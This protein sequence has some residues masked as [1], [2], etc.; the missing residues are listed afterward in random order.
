LTEHAQ[1]VTDT[2]SRLRPLNAAG[3]NQAIGDVKEWCVFTCG[4]ETAFLQQVA[5]VTEEYRDGL[6]LTPA[7]LEEIKK[8]HGDDLSDAEYQVIK[9]R[10]EP[11]LKLNQQHEELFLS[12]SGQSAVRQKNSTVNASQSPLAFLEGAKMRVSEKVK[13]RA[14]GEVT[15]TGVL[16]ADFSPD[17]KWELKSLEKRVV[18]QPLFKYAQAIDQLDKAATEFFSGKNSMALTEARLNAGARHQLMTNTTEVDIFTAKQNYDSGQATTDNANMTWKEW[19]GRLRRGM[20]TTEFFADAALSALSAKQFAAAEVLVTTAA[21]INQSTRESTQALQGFGTQAQNIEQHGTFVKNILRRP[22]SWVDWDDWSGYTHLKGAKEDMKQYAEGL[23]QLLKATD[24]Q[25]EKAAWSKIRSE[26]GK[27]EDKMRFIQIKAPIFE[28]ASFILVTAVT[29]GAGTLLTQG[30]LR[31]GAWAGARGLSMT[32]NPV[33]ITGSALSNSLAGYTATGIVLNAAEAGWITRSLYSVARLGNLRVMT[34]GGEMLVTGGLGFARTVALSV[35]QSTAG[36]A[37]TTFQMGAGAVAFENAASMLRSGKFLSTAENL[38]TFREG[39][40][41]GAMGPLFAAG[42]FLRGLNR[43][44]RFI[45]ATHSP[46]SSLIGRFAPKSFAASSKAAA[47]FAWFPKFTLTSIEGAFMFHTRMA[48]FTKVAQGIGHRVWGGEGKSESQL[49]GI[50]RQAHIIGEALAIGTPGRMH[51]PRAYISRESLKGLRETL[52]D[53]AENTP[54]KEARKEAIK[55]ARAEYLEIAIG[56]RDLIGALGG[57]VRTGPLL[58]AL[59]AVKLKPNGNNLVAFQKIQGILKA[60]IPQ[61]TR[62]ERSTMAQEILSAKGAVKGGKF[63]SWSNFEQNAARSAARLAGSAPEGSAARFNH[64]RL[65]L[66]KEVFRQ[67]QSGLKDGSLHWSGASAPAPKSP[68]LAPALS[69]IARIRLALSAVAQLW[70][71]PAPAIKFTAVKAAIEKIWAEP[72]PA[73]GA[74]NSP[75]AKTAPSGTTAAPDASKSSVPAEVQQLIGNMTNGAS[76]PAKLKI[77]NLLMQR[78]VSELAGITPA[79]RGKPDLKRQTIA[80]AI[81]RTAELFNKTLVDASQTKGSNSKT[82]LELIDTA[83]TAARALETTFGPKNKELRGIAKSVSKL[84]QS[85]LSPVPPAKSGSGSRPDLALVGRALALTGR[86]LGRFAEATR[87]LSKQLVQTLNPKSPSVARPSVSEVIKL[88]T[89]LGSESRQAAKAALQVLKTTAKELLADKTGLKNKIESANTAEALTNQIKDL[90]RGLLEAFRI[91][92]PSRQVRQTAGLV[93][94]LIKL[95]ANAFDASKITNAAEAKGFG[96]ALQNLSEA[97]L[98]VARVLGPMSQKVRAAARAILGASKAYAAKVNSMLVEARS[99]SQAD[100]A[101]MAEGLYAATE[102]FYAASV[103]AGIKSSERKE[104][105]DNVAKDFIEAANKLAKKLDETSINNSDSVSAA[106]MLL[107]M[108]DVLLEA[109]LVDADAVRNYADLIAGKLFG[110]GATAEILNTKLTNSTLNDIN[111]INLAVVARQVLAARGL[112][113]ADIDKALGGAQA[114]ALIAAEVAL[115]AMKTNPPATAD[116]YADQAE[117]IYRAQMTDAAR[118]KVLGALITQMLQSGNA[119]ALQRFSERAAKNEELAADLESALILFTV[120]GLEKKIRDANLELE[121]AVAERMAQELKSIMGDKNGVIGSRGVDMNRHVFVRGE[122]SRQAD[123]AL[124]TL[125]T[126]GRFVSELRARAIRMS[127][128][129][130]LE[131][132]KR[133]K[134]LGL[135]PEVLRNG[136][137]LAELGANPWIKIEAESFTREAVRAALSDI[138]GSTRASERLATNFIRRMIK[139]A[140]SEGQN[141]TVVERALLRLWEVLNHQANPLDPNSIFIQGFRRTDFTSEVLAEAGKAFAEGLGRLSAAPEP[142]SESGVV[143]KA[144]LPAEADAASVLARYLSGGAKEAWTLLKRGKYTT[145]T[146][147]KLLEALSEDQPTQSD[148]S[149]SAS[150]ETP[151]TLEQQAD[152]DAI[153]YVLARRLSEQTIND[154]LKVAKNTEVDFVSKNA[155]KPETT[156][157]SVPVEGKMDSASVNEPKIKADGP[158]IEA[159]NAFLSSAALTADTARLAKRG[160]ALELRGKMSLLGNWLTRLSRLKPFR[161]LTADGRKLS[162]LEREARAEDQKLQ[163]EK[164]R[165]E[166]LLEALSKSSSEEADTSIEPESEGIKG[167]REYV[168]DFN[169]SLNRERPGR[170]QYSTAQ[171][172]YHRVLRTVSNL[173]HQLGK[174]LNPDKGDPRSAVDTANELLR[175]RE[176]IDNNKLLSPF[177]RNLLTN[178]ITEILKIKNDATSEVSAL[179]KQTDTASQNAKTAQQTAGKRIIAFAESFDTASSKIKVLKAA[180]AKAESDL[181]QLE[182]ELQKLKMNQSDNST[183]VEAKISDAKTVLNEARKAET[184]A[185]KDAID[186]FNSSPSGSEIPNK[187][188]PEEL[189]K[190]DLSPEQILK[191]SEWVREHIRVLIEARHTTPAQKMQEVLSAWDALI[192]SADTAKKARAD[193][194]KNKTQKITLKNVKKLESQSRKLEKKSFKET[195]RNKR[196]KMRKEAA[197]ALC[198]AQFPRANRAYPIP[199]AHSP[200]REVPPRARQSNRAA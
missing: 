46:I 70:R 194:A 150:A 9:D 153:R 187:I 62:G 157:E 2:I 6:F 104:K 120:E 33:L 196:D 182:L 112:S 141:P 10:L 129:R 195:D 61:L 99:G 199:P 67:I 174:E 144:T 27:F 127:E 134:Q 65:A 31:F 154:I 98:S 101:Q 85:E 12:D 166:K 146:D 30:A 114:R 17:D 58:D 161:W 137:D 117:L 191:G 24:A 111:F 69:Y 177:N 51:T 164:S 23:A 72:V 139:V 124:D 77:L 186:T 49:R 96:K 21:S 53:V 25:S 47:F 71:G 38:N 32:A 29:W 52:K 22:L 158:L 57:S 151:K 105:V 108:Y 180:T 155:P 102:A 94:N 121:S 184:K 131:Q 142:T 20:E 136:L 87:S 89:N 200:W 169:D 189:A 170:I 50:D 3:V 149:A 122:A 13:V 143:K 183:G 107:S 18:D 60:A 56:P 39:L 76:R 113:E 160:Q 132:V 26:S 95:A 192:A 171:R 35:I 63:I 147:Q 78:L 14:A 15:L 165:L 125:R 138:E 19:E 55:K 135:S 84:A 88:L 91:L 5:T 103:L 79:E 118:G 90:S 44:S 152:S 172:A 48:F 82:R 92:G 167:L 123:R 162:S 163:N 109:R 106:R 36:V 159:I 188:T 97:L 176:N 40:W 81:K 80:D 59:N 115:T 128:Q 110:E 83:L 41:M 11:L 197:H 198:G 193:F 133:I 100:I 178:L 37:W 8:T 185:M 86:I 93:A 148:L 119:D 168:R 4:D 156:T 74:K 68:P 54:N 43:T 34:A 28:I 66:T 130:V 181:N 42:Q 1:T 7:R 64:Q 116:A 140:K 173:A 145:F 190:F 45:A 126:Q 73:P 179:V 75:K 16:T 175:M